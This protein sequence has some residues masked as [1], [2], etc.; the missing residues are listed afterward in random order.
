VGTKIPE[1]SAASL[2]TIK[3]FLIPQRWKQLFHP[4]SLCLFSKIHDITTQKMAFFVV[5]TV[6]TS[7]FAKCCSRL[8]LML[9][10]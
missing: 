5:T 9:I 6:V 7:D 2:F 10:V 1:E 8:D 4:K 3:E